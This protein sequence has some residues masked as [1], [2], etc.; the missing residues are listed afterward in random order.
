SVN[1]HNA[2]VDLLLRNV[3]SGQQIVTRIA[4]QLDNENMQALWKEMTEKKSGGSTVVSGLRYTVSSGHIERVLALL[5]A[6]A[7][8][9]AKDSIGGST[10]LTL[11]A[12]LDR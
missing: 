8:I 4:K 10:A 6:G 5:E 3:E 1:Q 2:M 11:A 7:D 12:W 9:D